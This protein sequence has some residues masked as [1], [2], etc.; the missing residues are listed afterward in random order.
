MEIA[1]VLGLLILAIILF[2]W[3]KLT[4]D[5]VTLIVLVCLISFGILTPAEAFAGFGSDFIVLLGSIFIISAALQ[6]TG[7]LDLIGSRLLKMARTNKSFL[8][9][10]IMT[11][12]GFTSAFMNNTTVTAI[13][14]APV[15]AVARRLKM[16]PS[17][18][19]MPVA[20]A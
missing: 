16:S 7:I 10:Y 14:I 6:Q 9:T 17:K 4:V 5:M 12:V 20:Y 11:A 3:E 19:L 18:L 2:S 1:L 15:I 8:I 13:F